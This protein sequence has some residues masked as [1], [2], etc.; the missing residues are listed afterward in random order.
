MVV[1]VVVMVLTLLVAGLVAGYVAYPHRGVQLPA[2][3]WLG[4]AL[5]R[6]ARAAPVLKEDEDRTFALGAEH[7]EDERRR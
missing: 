4:H 2:V 5:A 6:A 7:E 3:P 1:V